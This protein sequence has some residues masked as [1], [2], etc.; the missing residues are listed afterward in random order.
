MERTR[1][2]VNIIPISSKGQDI[3][4][5]KK[6]IPIGEVTSVSMFNVMTFFYKDLE[7]IQSIIDTVKTF[8]Q[9]GGYFYMILFDGELVMN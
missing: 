6:T 8:L 4:I 1:Q 9:S 3:D 5:L 7:T 2:K